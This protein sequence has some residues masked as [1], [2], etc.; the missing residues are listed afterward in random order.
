M[1]YFCSA[2]L[3]LPE[4]SVR[5]MAL[6]YDLT[7]QAKLFLLCNIWNDMVKN[8]PPKKSIMCNP[9][10]LFS[11]PLPAPCLFSLSHSHTLLPPPSGMPACL[12]YTRKPSM[13]I[14]STQTKRVT[15]QTLHHKDTWK[16]S[17]DTEHLSKYRWHERKKPAEPSISVSLEN[18]ASHITCRH[19]FIP[20]PQTYSYF[21]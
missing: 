2:S 14:P 8:Y 3:I 5:K 16:E 12:N 6:L 15:H 4:G 11:T 13:H 19:S 7:R 10:N 20:P 21:Y 9:K 1:F 18:Q 17:M